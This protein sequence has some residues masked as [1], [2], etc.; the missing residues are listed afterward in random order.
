MRNLKKVITVAALAISFGA[1][2]NVRAQYQA[3]GAD[4]IAASPKLRQ[5]LDE[6]KRVES[7]SSTTV[8]S[9]G[10][11]ATGED[12]ITASPKLRQMLNEQKS[13]AGAPSGAVASAGYQPTGLD[14]ITASPKLRQQLDERNKPWEFLVAPAR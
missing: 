12:G 10:Y 2:S 4:G 9:V 5:Q 11:Q 3:V 13:V 8:A 6:R 7:A 14:G 1:V